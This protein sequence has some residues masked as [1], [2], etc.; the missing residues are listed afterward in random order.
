MPAGA[1]VDVHF[2]SQAASSQ[3]AVSRSAAI[4]PWVLVPMIREPRRAIHGPIHAAPRR[5]VHGPGH[6]ARRRDVNGPGHAARRRD[7]NGVAVARPP[8]AY[9]A[10]SRDYARRAEVV[11]GGDEPAAKAAAESNAETAAEAAMA[12]LRPAAVASVAVRSPSAPTAV[13]TARRSDDPRRNEMAIGP[14]VTARVTASSIR[15]PAVRAAAGIVPATRKAALRQGLPRQSKNRPNAKDHHDCL[16]RGSH[17]ESPSFLQVVVSSFRRLH[18]VAAV[19]EQD[20]DEPPRLAEV[21]EG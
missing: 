4:R 9:H 3:H 21:G 10:R 7:V 6:A 12:V 5:D 11:I 8:G 16:V 19:T 20:S 17:F 15:R 18:V 14:V 13:G 1:E 2:R